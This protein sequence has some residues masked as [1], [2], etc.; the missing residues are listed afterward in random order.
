MSSKRDEKINPREGWTNIT[1][2]IKRHLKKKWQILI[3]QPTKEIDMLPILTDL[4]DSESK[5]L[6]IL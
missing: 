4:Y 1:H 6:R 3:S 2:E 5:F